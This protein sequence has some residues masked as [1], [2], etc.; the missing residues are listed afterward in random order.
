MALRSD[1]EKLPEYIVLDICKRLPVKAIINLSETNKT[2]RKMLMSEKGLKYYCFHNNLPLL[3]PVA[4][5][6]PTAVLEGQHLFEKA[7]RINEKIDLLNKQLKSIS[8]GDQMLYLY[9]MLEKQEELYGDLPTEK[10]KEQLKE[11]KLLQDEI[12]RNQ[13]TY[14]TLMLNAERKKNFMASWEEIKKNI[15]VSYLQN[16]SDYVWKIKHAEQTLIGLIP[17]FGRVIQLFLIQIYIDYA[18]VM[19]EKSKSFEAGDDDPA[20]HALFSMFD[21]PT[22][23]MLGTPLIS[24]GPALDKI[25]SDFEKEIKSLIAKAKNTLIILKSQTKPWDHYTSFVALNLLKPTGEIKTIP[26]LLNLFSETLTT[27]E[28]SYGLDKPNFRLS[29]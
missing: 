22:R 15:F 10:Q 8:G 1:F 12:K 11:I 3:M 4:K 14:F 24:Q 27:L 23:I 19:A 9:T 17:V 29:C 5:L 26:G 16:H 21:E 13:K 18:N 2:I 7:R 25:K 20:V 28:K 6:N